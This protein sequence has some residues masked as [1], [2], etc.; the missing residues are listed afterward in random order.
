MQVKDQEL[1]HREINVVLLNECFRYQC[2]RSERGFSHFVKHFGLYLIGKE[3]EVREAVIRVFP[4]NSNTRREN[5]RYIIKCIKRIE[6]D[7]KAVIKMQA[8]GK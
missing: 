4:L 7:K 5:L 6:N 8:V 2:A 3:D 1:T